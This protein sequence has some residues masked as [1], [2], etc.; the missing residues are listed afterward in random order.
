MLQ[1][2][3]LVWINVEKKGKKKKRNNNNNVKVLLLDS[4]EMG[5]V[6]PNVQKKIIIIPI[7]E[8]AENFLNV[9]Y[10]PENMV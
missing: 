3:I 1:Y 9:T 6:V 2:L 5:N 8:N 10:R 7:L 4:L